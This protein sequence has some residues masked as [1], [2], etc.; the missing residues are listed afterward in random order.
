VLIGGIDV[1]TL[2]LHY[3]RRHI[4]TVSQEPVL[5]SGSLRHNVAFGLKNEDES[6][7]SDEVV[8]TAMNRARVPFTNLNMDVG[9]RGSQVSGGQKQ[10]IAIARAILRNPSILVMDE[11]T[12]ALDSRTEREIMHTLDEVSEGRTVLLVAHRLSTIKKCHQIMVLETGKVVEKGTHEELVS[13]QGGH[14]AKLWAAATSIGLEK[15]L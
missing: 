7:I 11:A 6:D 1:R 9:V 13:M 12:S 5:F 4:A 2:N 8:M 3:L 10:R 15:Y 14:Y